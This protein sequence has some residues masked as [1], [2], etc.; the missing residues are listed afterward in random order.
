LG[1]SCCPKKNKIALHDSNGYWGI[2]EDGNWCGIE[3]RDVPEEKV[4]KKKIIL[5]NNI[6][7]I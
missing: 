5:K 3:T 4:K 7:I 1:Y 2:L 6:K